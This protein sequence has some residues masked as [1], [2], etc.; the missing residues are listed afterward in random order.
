ML[1]NPSDYFER[2]TVV[3]V[4]ELAAP[5]PQTRCNG[6]PLH[7]HFVSPLLPPC[8]PCKDDD[9]GT[10]TI[11]VSTPRLNAGAD[12]RALIRGISMARADFLAFVDDACHPENPGA[13]IH[14]EMC[15]FAEKMATFRVVWQIQN[16]TTSVLPELPP[17]F[18]SADSSPMLEI[19]SGYSR[20]V[21]VITHCD[22]DSYP[23][24]ALGKSLLC[25]PS[26]N[27]GEIESPR[28]G[29]MS[30]GRTASL[31]SQS[32][33][34]A[35]VE[36]LL[37]IRETYVTGTLPYERENSFHPVIDGG[38]ITAQI[39]E[40]IATASRNDTDDRLREQVNERVN[41][42]RRKR[43]ADMISLLVA[44]SAWN[45]LFVISLGYCLRLIYVTTDPQMTGQTKRFLRSPSIQVVFQY[46]EE[47]DWA[48]LFAEKFWW[49]DESMIHNRIDAF[50]RRY[51]PAEEVPEATQPRTEP[52][53]RESGHSARRKRHTRKR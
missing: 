29:E 34:T 33:A 11:I 32:I 17:V 19:I 8:I 7:A 4:N 38:Y 20:T 52:P 53:K 51:E 16:D 23:V 25:L 48:L 21:A 50:L 9:D 5:F 35:L 15:T 47:L 44:S 41:R 1:R 36:V 3:L 22:P 14:S 18:M 39:I 13:D 6:L 49:C 30:G 42:T 37:N 2:S 40:T 27:T 26:S 28:L 43:K 10:A 45:V 31:N 24:Y 12:T 46:L